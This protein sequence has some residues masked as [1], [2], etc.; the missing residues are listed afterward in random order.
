MCSVIFLACFVLS[1]PDLILT[2]VWNTSS[3]KIDHCCWKRSI[4]VYKNSYFLCK[5]FKVKSWQSVNP[6]TATEP[7]A[8][9]SFHILQDPRQIY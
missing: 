3:V 9:T 4:H 8:I 6:C 1:D 2:T 5:P 7:H